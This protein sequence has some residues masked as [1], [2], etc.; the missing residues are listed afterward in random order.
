MAIGLGIPLLVAI[1]GH[2][3]GQMV[4]LG[5]WYE[6][7][8][9]AFLTATPDQVGEAYW[10]HV[11][12]AFRAL[13]AAAV[14]VSIE[15]VF[16]SE[17]GPLGAYGEFPVPALERQGTRVL[18]SLDA[19]MGPNI[20]A[21]VRLTVG[22]RLTRPGQKRMWGLYE[23]D[24]DAGGYLGPIYTG[25]LATMAAFWSAPIILGAPVATGVLTPIVTHRDPVTD[26]ITDYQDVTGFIVKPEVTTQN[27]RK[28]GV[29]A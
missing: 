4:Q 27:S 23:V 14:Q 11:K 21:G 24:N 12:V 19:L 18:G 16:V 25:L 28:Y 8:G 17:D 3:L 2:Y 6:T 5:Q 1:R 13:V 20:A 7:D 10:N 15:S 22:T 29:G 9:A 26:L